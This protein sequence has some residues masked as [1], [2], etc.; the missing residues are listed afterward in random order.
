MVSSGRTLGFLNSTIP[1]TRIERTKEEVRSKGK[2]K[3]SFHFHFSFFIL[4]SPF[5]VNAFSQSIWAGTPTDTQMS[6]KSIKLPFSIN[7]RLFNI[8]S[9]GSILFLFF[10]LFF[11]L[12]FSTREDVVLLQKMRIAL[13]DFHLLC[14]APEA[15]YGSFEQHQSCLCL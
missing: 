11:F 6:G 13:A 4:L 15:D 10:S 3:M 12:H 9:Y 5:S 7:H 2:R 1:L 14:F 8:S